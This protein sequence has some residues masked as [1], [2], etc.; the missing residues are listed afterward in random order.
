MLVSLR[1]KSMEWGLD[2]S[3]EFCIASSAWGGRDLLHGAHSG[4]GMDVMMGF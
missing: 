2:V 1:A 3:L 4:K